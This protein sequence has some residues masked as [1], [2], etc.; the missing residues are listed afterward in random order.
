[1]GN[2]TSAMRGGQVIQIESIVL[3]A[4]AGLPYQGAA[5]DN[6]VRRWQERLNGTWR[7]LAGGCNLNRDVPALLG[8]A[9]YRLD[10]CTAA[11]VPRI[12]RGVGFHYRG[13]ATALSD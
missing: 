4:R 2:E 7:R 13:I 10:E 9:G 5:P 11:Y 8:A 3:D 12:P 6:S 1:M